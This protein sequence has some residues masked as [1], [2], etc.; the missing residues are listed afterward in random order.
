MVKLDMEKVATSGVECGMAKPERIAALQVALF[1]ACGGGML[2]HFAAEQPAD[3]YIDGRVC[4]LPYGKREIQQA[5]N[6]LAI[7]AAK[8]GLDPHHMPAMPTFHNAGMF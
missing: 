4:R 6:V 8:A 1:V 7:L 5:V 2:G 3:F